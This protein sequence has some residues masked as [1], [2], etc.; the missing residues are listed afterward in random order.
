MISHIHTTDSQGNPAISLFIE[1]DP[2]NIS[3]DHIN[4]DKINKLLLEGS[5]DAKGL[6]KLIDVRR[7][8]RRNLSN[9]ITLEN[10][11]FFYKGDEI[12]NKVTD[13]ILEYI[14]NS[15]EFGHLV[16]FLSK[17][18]QN[19]SKRSVDLAWEYLQKYKM[20]IDENG[21]FWA[22]KAVTSDHKDKW[23][24]T[25][26][27]S[28]GQHVQMNR[29]KISDDP[30]HACHAGLHCGYID[31]VKSY[32]YN[33]DRIIKIEVNPRDIV[34]IPYSSEMQKMRVCEYTVTQDLGS[35]DEFF[36]KGV[37]AFKSNSVQDIQPEYVE[38]KTVGCSYD[39]DI[40]SDGEVFCNCCGDSC[41]GC[42]C[43]DCEECDN[44]CECD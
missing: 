26:D 16:K 35:Y 13:L 40:D 38:K 2:I 41:M 36:I 39:S 15:Y 4:Y 30:N 29:N 19:P 12:H 31:Y 21:N 7:E 24:R 20:P 28:V 44:C 43:S 11:K 3:S 9:D 1:G 37:G 34:C 6:L 5:N 23:T 27:N 42:L 25:I 14:R 8:I 18:M 33:N 32:G 17:L 10:D 22:L